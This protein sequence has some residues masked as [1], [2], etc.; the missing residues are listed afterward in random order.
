MVADFDQF[1]YQ[2][3][4]GIITH[5]CSWSQIILKYLLCRLST[6]GVLWWCCPG[7]TSCA[8]WVEYIL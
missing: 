2:T 7:N 3:I 6:L 8:R 5:W 1:Q 4:E